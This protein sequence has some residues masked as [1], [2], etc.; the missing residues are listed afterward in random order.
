[1]QRT[2]TQLTR[3][4]N[5]RYGISGLKAALDMLGYAGGRVRAPLPCV[6]DEARREIAKVLTES[7]LLTVE[8]G[9]DINRLQAGASI[10]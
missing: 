6:N 10:K 3:G 7:G 1:M 5:G 2:L 4:I 8:A 9:D